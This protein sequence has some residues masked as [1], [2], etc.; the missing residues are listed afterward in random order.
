MIVAAL[1]GVL[2]L[3]LDVNEPKVLVTVTVL[4]AS[5][6]TTFSALTSGVML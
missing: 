4:L 5:I 1:A 6:E 2:K 3:L